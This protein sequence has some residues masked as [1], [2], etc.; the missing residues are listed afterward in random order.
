MASRYCEE[1]L[2]LSHSHAH[3]PVQAAE[4][5]GPGKN[6]IVIYIPDL[7]EPVQA[8]LAAQPDSFEAGWRYIEESKSQVLE[9]A[10]PTGQSLAI[11]FINGIH[12]SLL[13]R[14]AHGATLV[15][16]PYP[17]YADGP[18]PPQTLFSPETSLALPGAP[19]PLSI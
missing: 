12:N 18:E 8:I 5:S 17:L 15:L 1:V 13:G 19:S 2:A 7:S 14:L 9:I 4:F 16:S 6:A 11:A 10:F 3:A